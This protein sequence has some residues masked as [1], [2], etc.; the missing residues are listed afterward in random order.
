MFETGKL[1]VFPIVVGPIGT[2]C[3]LVVNKETKN[4]FVVDPGAQADVIAQRIRR[5]QAKLQGILLTH[6]HFDHIMAVRELKELFPAEV[7]AAEKETPLLMDPEANCSRGF[8]MG[9]GYIVKPDR[10]V[11]DK[12]KLTLADVT[13]EVMETPGHTKGGVCFYI[14]EEKLLFCG[15]TLFEESIGRSDLPTG[16]AKELLHSLKEK[17]L[18]LPEEVVAFPGHG[19]STKIGH[20][21]KYNPYA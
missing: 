20:E 14:E 16:S 13:V 19:S 8:G 3:Y 5:E 15:D 11:K 18:V 12:E 10:E 17:V 7:Y 21:K 9:S 4:A 2:N 1:A 6:G